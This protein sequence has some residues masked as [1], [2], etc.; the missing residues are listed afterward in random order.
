VTLAP[1]KR[2]QK[3]LSEHIN[4]YNKTSYMSIAKTIRQNQ[5]QTRHSSEHR[6]LGSATMHYLP[7]TMIKHTA[8]GIFKSSLLQQTMEGTLD[9]KKF[10]LLSAQK[11]YRHLNF[12]GFET[13]TSNTQSL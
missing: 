7:M 6:L 1:P 10:N 11:Q 5:S 4:F 12:S 9:R 2:Q 8:P 13:T 3:D